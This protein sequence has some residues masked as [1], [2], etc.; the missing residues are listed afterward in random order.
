MDAWL[1]IGLGLGVVLVLACFSIGAY[2]AHGLP[3]MGVQTGVR[4]ILAAVLIE[5]AVKVAYLAC[6][7]PDRHLGPFKEEDRIYMVIGAFV[8]V[9][10]ALADIYREAGPVVGWG[11]A[12]AGG[13][14]SDR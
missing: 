14:P 12:P 5:A 11:A 3:P 13:S 10:V 2:R 9:C 8:T 6:T 1:L 4:L 7:T